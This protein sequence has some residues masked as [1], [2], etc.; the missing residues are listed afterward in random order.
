MRRRA[1]SYHHNFPAAN[2]GGSA[3]QAANPNQE[4]IS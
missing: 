1:T 3:A 4:S 2:F